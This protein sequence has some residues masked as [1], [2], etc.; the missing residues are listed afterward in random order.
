MFDF[1]KLGLPQ[2][3]HDQMIAAFG[4]NEWAMNGARQAGNTH[5]EG[6]HWAAAFARNQ[7]ISNVFQAPE[8]RTMPAREQERVAAFNWRRD[9]NRST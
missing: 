7:P 5:W 2:V 4:S 3:V 1:S 8:I 9:N 6:A